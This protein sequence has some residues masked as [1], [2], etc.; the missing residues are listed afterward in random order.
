ML[1][2]PE[3]LGPQTLNMDVMFLCTLP[4]E[5]GLVAALKALV[6]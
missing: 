2:S 6:T 4:R 3:A 1:S 5:A